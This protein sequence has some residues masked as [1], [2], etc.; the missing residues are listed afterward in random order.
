MQAVTLSGIICAAAIYDI[1]ETCQNKLLSLPTQAT[2]QAVQFLIGLQR[3][4]V[5]PLL[6]LFG[7][8]Y[9]TIG[10]KVVFEC[11]PD[12]YTGC[13]RAHPNLDLI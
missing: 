7:D 13:N 9:K 4:C 1:P 10:K 11:G 5:P 8:S 12:Q 2:N 3:M 6:S